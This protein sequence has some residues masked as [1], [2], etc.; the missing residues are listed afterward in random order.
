MPDADGPDFDGAWAAYP[1]LPSGNV[2]VG[3]M[4]QNTFAR[5]AAVSGAV[6][7]SCQLVLCLRTY[8]TLYERAPSQ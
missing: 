6:S 8:L 7:E 5:P 4:G 1:Y 2:L 3:G